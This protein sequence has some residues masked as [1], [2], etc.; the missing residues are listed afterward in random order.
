M[1]VGVN[2]KNQK[3]DYTPAM[4]VAYFKEIACEK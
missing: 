3:N 4:M 1:S 2:Q